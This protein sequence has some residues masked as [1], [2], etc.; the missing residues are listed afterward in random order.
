MLHSSLF[1]FVALVSEVYWAN[2]FLSD[3]FL[4]ST[5]TYIECKILQKMENGKN[6]TN[7]NYFNA[8]FTGH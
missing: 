5:K 3:L 1:Q 2:V 8:L 4:V 6:D 7:T